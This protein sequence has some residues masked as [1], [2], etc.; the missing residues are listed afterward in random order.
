[1]N[2]GLYIIIIV[3][4]D[5]SPICLLS[6]INKSLAK[7]EPRD[8]CNYWIDVYKCYRYYILTPHDVF[9]TTKTREFFSVNIFIAFLL[10][11][12]HLEPELS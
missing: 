3:Y 7:F 2:F 8:I 10:F 11:F 1:M 4:N 9:S 5:S 6:D 12:V